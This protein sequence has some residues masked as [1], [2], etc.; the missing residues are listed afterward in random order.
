[1]NVIN[2]E[3]INGSNICNN[4]SNCLINN[5]MKIIV[6]YL[7]QIYII[8]V[9]MVNMNFLNILILILTLNGN[10]YYNNLEGYYLYP[11]LFNN[12]YYGIGINIHAR[13]PHSW[14]YI[15]LVIIR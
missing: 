14:C 1:M 5:D 4:I 3:C 6:V 7:L 2:K 15:K 11:I 9:I 12:F 13:N 10:I 8:L